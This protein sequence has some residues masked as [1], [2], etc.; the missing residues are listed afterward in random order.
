MGNDF[1]GAFLGIS[2]LV[3]PPKQ[4]ALLISL[5]ADDGENPER[6]KRERDFWRKYTVWNFDAWP[7]FDSRETERRAID[8]LG[9][10]PD[11]V[12]GA[13]I[14]RLIDCEHGRHRR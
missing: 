2:T 14:R 7:R 8:E 12:P 10:D 4:K 13:A 6:E 11:A 5:A 3:P 1:P 9:F